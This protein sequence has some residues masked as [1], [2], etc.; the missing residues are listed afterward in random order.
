MVTNGP[1]WGI[2][3]SYLYSYSS[4][5]FPLLYFSGSF[6]WRSPLIFFVAD[7]IAQKNKLIIKAKLMVYNIL[8]DKNGRNEEIDLY[9]WVLQ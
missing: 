7:H 2:W 9:S 5:I 6:L 3:W 1:Y 8:V 4:G